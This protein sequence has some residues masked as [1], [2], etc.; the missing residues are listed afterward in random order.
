MRALGWLLF[1][2]FLLYLLLPMLAPVV[3]SFSRLWLGVLPEGFTLEGY[4]R[5]LQDPKYLEA[6]LLS[7]RIALLAVLLNVLVGV[8]T[9]YVAH[10]WAGRVGEGLRRLL[11]VLPL[12][13]PPL[14]VGLGF[15]LAF[16]RPPLALS[17]TLWIVVLGHAALGFPFFFRTVYAGLAG[18]EVRLLMEAAQASGAGLGARLRY[19]L[20]PNLL[21]AVLSGAL[22]AFAISMGEFEVTSMVAGFGTITLP[23]LLFQSL[24]EDFRSA[25]AVASALLYVT[26]LALVGLTLLRR[27]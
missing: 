20:L 7:L 16:N 15:L 21:P 24:R 25:S 3:Y 2:L 11:Q 1:L 10:L 9:A 23:L 26:L 4:A 22:V 17:G 19:V 27:R 13:V 18:L 5:I 8:P 14:V 12:L 6:A